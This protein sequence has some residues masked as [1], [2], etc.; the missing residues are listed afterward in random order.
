MTEYISEENCMLCSKMW[1]SERPEFRRLLD[2]IPLGEPV[3]NTCL[4]A[5][6]R[7]GG[8]PVRDVPLSARYAE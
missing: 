1:P 8:F 3:C 6:A 5:F 7:N 2:S 4:M